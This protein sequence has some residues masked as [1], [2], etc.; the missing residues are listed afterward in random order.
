VRDL[1]TPQ[2]DA[3]A[4][5]PRLRLVTDDGERRLYELMK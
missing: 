3:A 1:S 5:A 2:V 4:A